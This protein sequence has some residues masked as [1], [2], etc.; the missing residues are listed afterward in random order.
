MD[1]EKLIEALERTTYRT[2]STYSGDYV[3]LNIIC[4]DDQKAA[5]RKT[6]Y[7][8][9]TEQITDLDLTKRCA[10][11]EA[12]VFAYEAMIANSNFAP[13]IG[14]QTPKEKTIINLN[15]RIKVLLTEHGKDL[16]YHRYDAMI[17]AGVFK[18]DQRPLPMV[19]NEGKTEF[20]LWDFISLYGEHIG[21]CEDPIIQP[22]IIERVGD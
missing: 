9:A 10:E 12:K 22:L 19:D 3:S 21:I 8:W 20:Q 14:K 17:E 2:K 4:G 15:D 1:V 6:V 5:L 11:L 16:Y 7:G 18:E 13:M